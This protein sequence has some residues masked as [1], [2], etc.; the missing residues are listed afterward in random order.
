VAEYFE[1]EQ[2]F[3]IVMEYCKDPNYFQ[4]R[5]ENKLKQFDDEAVLKKIAGNVLSA[6]IEIHRNNVIHC[7]IKPENFLLFRGE[8]N[9]DDY[10]D[11]G[12]EDEDE[13][14]DVENITVKLT[15]FGLSHIIPN[16]SSKAYLKYPCG[17]YG[18]SAPEKKS[19]C[20]ID[21][22]AD[23]WSF[24]VCLYQMAV[25]YKPTSIKNYKYGS[26]PIPFIPNHWKCFD[27][28]NLRNLIESCLKINPVERIT[29][30]EAIHHPWF[31]A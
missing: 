29:A 14:D 3:F 20:Y 31:D 5:L 9:F 25:A 7:D 24:G 19:D 11:E 22:S 30:E 10:Q 18:Y 6:L 13:E 21:A 23:M 1:S 17:S 27:F 4:Y 8:M 12:S 26:G 15:D 2:S 28:S 16:G